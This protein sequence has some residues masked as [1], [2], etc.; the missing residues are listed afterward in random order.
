MESSGPCSLTPI[1]SGISR[2]PSLC[3]ILIVFQWWPSECLHIIPTRFVSFAQSKGLT[4]SKYLCFP[5]LQFSLSM[6]RVCHRCGMVL[7][8]CMKDVDRMS[9]PKRWRFHWFE[10]NHVTSTSGFHWSAQNGSQLRQED[11]DSFSS[12]H[13][14]QANTKVSSGTLSCPVSVLKVWLIIDGFIQSLECFSCIVT[15]PPAPRTAADVWLQ[16]GHIYELQQQYDKAM[17]A[18][19]VSC[20]DNISKSCTLWWHTD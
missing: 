10:E 20:C 6:V 13:Y 19:Q 15:C 3:S 2:M 9:M 11:R 17:E 8:C 7:E 16:I 14:L 1:C 5:P 18:Y 12:W 4:G